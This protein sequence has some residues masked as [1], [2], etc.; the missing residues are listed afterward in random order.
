M[1]WPGERSRAWTFVVVDVTFFG[2]NAGED[3]FLGMGMGMGRGG[4]PGG[5]ERGVLG[6]FLVPVLVL[7]VG[8]G[9]RGWVLRG[10]EEVRVVM[11][12]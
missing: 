9:V 8:G 11:D 7:V 12:R 6:L 10:S 2:V 4:R 3:S 1:A 5:G